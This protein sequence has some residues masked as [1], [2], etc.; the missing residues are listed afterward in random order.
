MRNR[1]EKLLI[2]IMLLLFSCSKSSN[3]TAVNPL[4]LG[5]WTET[6]QSLSKCLNSA[7]DYS[8]PC[9]IA[10]CQ[11]ITIL[12]N[13]TWNNKSDTL[14]TTLP[15]VSGTYIIS[16]D[17]II[18]NFYQEFT[19]TNSVTSYSFSVQDKTLILSTVQIE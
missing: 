4:L 6:G 11:T 1:L 13:N 19:S 8:I 3:P 17:K 15:I 2:V 7:S 18:G 10:V 16:G 12:S 14:A 5:T 9:M